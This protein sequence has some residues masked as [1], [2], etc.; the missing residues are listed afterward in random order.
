MRVV[1][2]PKRILANHST[3]LVHSQLRAIMASLQSG[4]RNVYHLFAILTILNIQP[5]PNL[6][7][8]LLLQEQFYQTHTFVV[9][10]QAHLNAP[11]EGQ[12]ST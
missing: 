8:L 10:H 6:P 5:D 7:S 12:E 9:R 11:H 1:C 2:E 3:M 4:R